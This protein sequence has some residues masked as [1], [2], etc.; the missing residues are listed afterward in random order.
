MKCER[1]ALIGRRHET[2]HIKRS[3]IVLPIGILA[4]Q[5]NLSPIKDKG[6]RSPELGFRWP[7]LF[8]GWPFLW[9]QKLCLGSVV[10][11]ANF[12]PVHHVPKR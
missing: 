10:A 1:V 3:A 5:D 11:F 4:R 12:F 9:I 2:L 7:G 6:H 8:S